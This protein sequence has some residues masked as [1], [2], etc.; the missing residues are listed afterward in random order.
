[1]TGHASRETLFRMSQ[2]VRERLTERVL[3]TIRQGRKPGDL[4]IKVHRK[5]RGKIEMAS[6]R[7]RSIVSRVVPR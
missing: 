6:L 1:M 5:S 3:P 2:D 7:V 4:R